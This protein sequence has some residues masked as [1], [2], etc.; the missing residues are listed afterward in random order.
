MMDINDLA[1]QKKN[2]KANKQNDYKTKTLSLFRRK[3]YLKHSKAFEH[4][5]RGDRSFLSNPCILN[6]LHR[7]GV[8]STSR[9]LSRN[10]CRKYHF[11]TFA[12][13]SCL[14]PVMLKLKLISVPSEVNILFVLLSQDGHIISI[15][16]TFCYLGYM[17]T[18]DELQFVSAERSY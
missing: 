1:T 6:G 13:K 14:Y 4:F 17:H 12:G 3:N 9:L 18:L 11:E 7:I 8:S 15:K 5:G 16:S 10:F 2:E